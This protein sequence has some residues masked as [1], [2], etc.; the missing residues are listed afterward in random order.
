MLK[1][2]YTFKNQRFEWMNIQVTS[3]THTVWIIQTTTTFKFRHFKHRTDRISNK[4]NLKNFH[5][6]PKWVNERIG[7]CYIIV[8][9]LFFQLFFSWLFI[10]WRKKKHMKIVVIWIELERK[11]DSVD[12][13]TI[14]FHS[15]RNDKRFVSFALIVFQE[16]KKRKKTQRQ[17]LAMMPKKNQVRSNEMG[18]IET[19]IH[20]SIHRICS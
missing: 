12:F 3:K 18:M 9:I 6:K 1:K 13:L 8:K 20:I 16:R 4:K 10:Y 15:S 5:S 14:L 7:I 11:I 2:L 17:Y 19:C